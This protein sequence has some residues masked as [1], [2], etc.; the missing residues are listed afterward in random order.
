MSFQQR[1]EGKAKKVGL[2]EKTEG[3][4]RGRRSL[5]PPR[6]SSRITTSF[7]IMAA[8]ATRTSNNNSPH[9]SGKS[10]TSSPRSNRTSLQ[11]SG[12]YACCRH[13]PPQPYT[14]VATIE[15]IHIAHVVDDNVI[16]CFSAPLWMCLS[17]TDS[18][19]RHPQY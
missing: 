16:A 1:N 18:R 11:N 14:H 3:G 7:P 2:G 4:K 17:S 10:M 15:D 19:C 9:L 13:W 8:V 12:M 6:N 5:V